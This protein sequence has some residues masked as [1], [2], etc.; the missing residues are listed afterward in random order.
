MLKKMR[1][2]LPLIEINVVKET[3]IPHQEIFIFKKNK[4]CTIIG[5]KYNEHHLSEACSPLKFQ[6]FKVDW[7]V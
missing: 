6:P 1:K 4:R 7:S 3:Q 5:K 2:I